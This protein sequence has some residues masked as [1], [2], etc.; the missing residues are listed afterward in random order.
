MSERMELP[1]LEDFD[2]V[3]E[4]EQA[5]N[6]WAHDRLYGQQEDDM[7]R[8]EWAGDE[9]D[10]KHYDDLTDRTCPECN[11]S[12]GDKWNDGVVPCKFCHSAGYIG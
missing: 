10:D 7:A 8:L 3:E 6:M 12:G 5:M 1:Q 2:T 4:Y 11:G 9:E